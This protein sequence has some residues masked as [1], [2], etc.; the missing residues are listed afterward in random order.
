MALILFLVIPAGYAV[1]GQLLDW[2]VAALCFYSASGRRAG[3]WVS[4]CSLPVLPGLYLLAM[5]LGLQGD[6]GNGFE[7]FGSRFAAEVAFGVPF[8]G[9][10]ILMVFVGGM[11]V[12]RDVTLGYRANT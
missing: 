8:W 9:I 11:Y 10:P 2:S 12:L 3:K 6:V 5:V 7:L 1:L 4:R